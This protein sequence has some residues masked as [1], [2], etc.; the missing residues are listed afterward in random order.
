MGLPQGPEW[1]AIAQTVALNSLDPNTLLD[2][3]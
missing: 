1:V 3:D 2:G